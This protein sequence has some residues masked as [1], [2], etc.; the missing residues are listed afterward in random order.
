VSVREQ[1][2]FLPASPITDGKVQL[3]TLLLSGLHTVV[4]RVSP[5]RGFGSQTTRSDSRGNRREFGIGWN[6]LVDFRC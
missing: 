2:N 4:H 1:V 5:R 6:L 3:P